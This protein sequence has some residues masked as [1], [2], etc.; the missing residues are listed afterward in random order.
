MYIPKLMRPVHFEH[1]KVTNNINIF[2]IIENE[3]KR[4]QTFN[5]EYSTFVF[6][7]VLCHT[8]TKI[9]ATFERKVNSSLY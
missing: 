6:R 2:T 1:T 4:Q 5:S 9:A 3:L 8:L 7:L